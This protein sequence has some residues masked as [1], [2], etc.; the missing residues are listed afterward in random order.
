MNTKIKTLVAIAFMGTLLLVISCKDKETHNTNQQ[1]ETV[2]KQG[3][4]YSSAYVCPMHCQGS[5]SEHEGTCP[6]CEMTYVINKDYIKD[7]H[8]H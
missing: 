7:E 6:K 2:K 8:Q 1:T 3:K 4:E 5:G